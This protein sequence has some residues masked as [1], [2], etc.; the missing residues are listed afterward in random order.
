MEYLLKASAVIFIFYVC[1]KLFLQR[2]TFFETNRWFLLT[3]IFASLLLPFIVIP[4]YVEYVPMVQQF[5]IANDGSV[6]ST[7]VEKS[8]DWI[9][10]A[11]LIYGLGALFIT[12]KLSI[13]FSSLMSLL[14][15]SRF[16]KKGDYTFIETQHKVLPFSF[17]KNIVYNKNQFSESELNHIINH[18]KV[19]AKQYH[20]LDVMLIQLLSAVFWFNPF[21]W[22]YKKEL[23]QNLEFIADKEAQ[24][25]SNCEKSYQ[26]LLL[27]AS[28]PNYQLV[29]A[30]NFYNSLIKKRIVMLHK[31]KSSKLNV[32]K[33][34]L[35]LPVL[36]VFL[37]SANTK[38]IYVE[39]ATPA[40]DQ[41]SSADPSVTNTLDNILNASIEEEP[42][43]TPPTKVKTD[44]ANKKQSNKN[45]SKNVTSSNPIS[46]T[47]LEQDMVMITKDFTDAQLED[48]KKELAEKG[49]TVKFKGIKRNGDNEITAIKIEVSSKKSNANYHTENDKPILPIKIGFDSEGGS[50]SIGNSGPKHAPH[51]AYT[52]VNK[53]GKYKIHTA[54]NADNVFV[55][56]SDDD[57]GSDHS[58]KIVVRSAGKNHVIR[59]KGKTVWV[60]K[61]DSDTIV[62]KEMKKGTVWI[63]NDSDG[64]WVG[65]ESDNKVYEFKKGGNNMFFV[66][67]DSD[68]NPLFILDGKEITKKE[69]D[70]LDPDSIEKIEVL[71]GDNA[72]EKYGDK[73][74]DGVI[75]ITTKDKK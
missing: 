20:S 1:Y 39:K 36:A 41:V 2:E 64:K 74:K 9:Q 48:L 66:S 8:L 26:T 28:I 69:M 19:H 42:V 23:Q 43:A 68:K 11:S 16:H 55:I 75:L 37:M 65:N 38:E 6:T 15:K 54:G 17:F 56:A 10:V 32:W 73:G 51:D 5:I 58:E 60:P 72:T 63:S 4:V 30:N 71:K 50:L 67:T 49:I 35:I 70:A 13:E 57:N 7:A 46:G 3:G 21:I 45:Q 62:L 14:R 22:L 12:I 61:D 29:L 53:D 34:A 18:E 47:A 44:T 25:I 33:Y 40:N 27:K 24:T 31:S 59:S 52:I